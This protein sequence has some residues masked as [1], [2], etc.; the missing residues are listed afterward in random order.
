MVLI[1]GL[2]KISLIDFEPYTTAVV[3]LGGCNFR[4]GFCHNPDLV[5]R[6]DE[7]ETISEDDFFSFL[8]SR[9]KWL[10]G[11]CIT[12]GEPCLYPDLLPFILKIKEKGLLIKLD[13][14][15][16]NPSMIKELIEKKVVDYIAMDVKADFDNY[17][18]VAGVKVDIDKIKESISLIKGCGVDYEFRTTVVPGL[19]TKEDVAKIGKY[20]D[21][22]KKYVIQNFKA[23]E[24]MIENRFKNIKPYKKGELEEMKGSVKDFFEE[25]LVRE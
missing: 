18:V 13:T 3:F 4:C 15:G 12:G 10:D 16:S 19:V 5:V 25:V 1:K 24:N 21:G 22:S 6:A 17:D 23:K 14:N 9:K 2:Q 7:I 20:L 11:V 8:D